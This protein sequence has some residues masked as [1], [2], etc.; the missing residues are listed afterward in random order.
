M[1][2]HREQVI[3]GFLAR[4]VSAFPAAEVE[5]D[6]PWPKRPAPGGQVILH[7]GDPGEAEESFSPHQFTWRHELELEL[8]APTAPTVEQRHQLMDDM[9]TTLD[10]AIASDRSLGGL[11]AWL[12]P[13]SSARPD[14]VTTENGQPLRAAQVTVMAEYTTS[15]RLG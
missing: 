10:A 3:V 5:R 9:L 4:L 14:D 6:A 15:S 12:E 1:A 7:D 8:F 13:S 11:C 2:S